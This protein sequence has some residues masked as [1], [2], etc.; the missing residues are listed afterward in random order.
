MADLK[1]SSGSIDDL[2]EPETEKPKRAR[3]VKKVKTTKPEGEQSESWSSAAFINIPLKIRVAI[4]LHGTYNDILI[5]FVLNDF[6][7]PPPLNFIYIQPV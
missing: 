5:W 1:V 3:K 2:E 7:F 6:R 4:C